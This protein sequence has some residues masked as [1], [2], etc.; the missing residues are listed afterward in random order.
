MMSPEHRCEGESKV[1][2]DSTIGLGS[3][4]PDGVGDGVVS[5]QAIADELQ[6]S[7]GASTAGRAARTLPVPPGGSLRQTVLALVAGGSLQEH[8][9]PGAATLQ[10][11]RGRVRLS[12]DADVWEL[13][14]SDLVAIP[15]RRHGLD[16]L[17]DA[18][19][20]LTVAPGS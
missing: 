10:V 2:S 8:E 18:V 1:G 17:A 15:E 13:G 11:L 14:V 5:L 4:Q 20:L 6:E 12:A 19:V 7:V 3:T 9:S 16:A